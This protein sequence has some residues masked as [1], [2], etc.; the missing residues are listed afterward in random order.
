MNISL[1]RFATLRNYQRIDDR[2][3]RAFYVFAEKN[4]IEELEILK[5]VT[6]GTYQEIIEQISGKSLSNEMQIYELRRFQDGRIYELSQILDNSSRANLDFTVLDKLS[7]SPEHDLLSEHQESTLWD[8]LLQAIFST[9]KKNKQKV[10]AIISLLVANN[11]LK[12][13]DSGIDYSNDASLEK[14]KI[15]LR[16]IN[17]KVVLPLVIYKPLKSRTKTVLLSS[18]QKRAIRDKHNLILTKIEIAALNNAKGE[19]QDISNASISST[20]NNPVFENAVANPVRL[21]SES[22]GFISPYIREHIK[23]RLSVT[24]GVNSPE[25]PTGSS[26]EST[27]ETNING[28]GYSTIEPLSKTNSDQSTQSPLADFP[29]KLTGIPDDSPQI[30]LTRDEII[31]LVPSKRSKEIL[32][33]SNA[34]FGSIKSIEETLSNTIRTKFSKAIRAKSFRSIVAEFNGTK[35]RV[36]TMP[37]NNSFI[38]T[39]ERRSSGY[40]IFFTQYFQ[41]EHTRIVDLRCKFSFTDENIDD[42]NLEGTEITSNFHGFV[43]FQLNNEPVTLNFEKY[44]LVEVALIYRTTS[45]LIEDVFEEFP[46]VRLFHPLYGKLKIKPDFILLPERSPVY[47]VTNLGIIDFMRVEQ[48][49]VCYELGDVSHIENIMAKEYKEKTSKK[50]LM[51]EVSRESDTTSELETINETATTE[52]FELQSEISEALAMEE[53]ENLSLNSGVTSKFFDTT[54][55]VDFG[56]E[57]SSSNS[58]EE[59][60]R[61]ATNQAKE[62]VEKAKERIFSKI[63]RKISS[64]IRNEYE[65]VNKHGF[66][67][68]DNSKPVVSI[69]RWLDKISENQ[70]VNYGKRLVYEFMVPE[71]GMN[72]LMSLQ[73][74]DSENGSNQGDTTKNGGNIL[75]E[76]PVHPKVLLGEDYESVTPEQIFAIAAD[77]GVSLK[78]L[79]DEHISVSKAYSMVIREGGKEYTTDDSNAFNDFQIPEGYLCTDF[80][81]NAIAGVHEGDENDAWAFIIIG[82]QRIELSYCQRHDDSAYLRRRATRRIPLEAPLQGTVAVS[83]ITNDIGTMGFTVTAFCKIKQELLK[84]WKNDS[85]QSLVAEYNNKVSVYNEEQ[86]TIEAS[87]IEPTAEP[88]E[89]EFNYN[90][91]I[92]RKIERNELKRLCIEMLTKGFD[93]ETAWDFYDTSG[94]V[95]ELSLD[96]DFDTRV[97][98]VNF[99]ETAFE[100][101]LMAYKCYPYFYATHQRWHIL[102]HQGGTTDEL[103]KSFLSSGMAKV[104]LPVRT[105]Y[106]NAV[107]FFLSTGEVWH[108]SNFIL[109]TDDDVDI[110]INEELE[111]IREEIRIEDKWQIRVP[112]SLTIVQDGAQAVDEDGLPCRVDKRVETTSKLLFGEEE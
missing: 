61:I 104:R 29:G 91:N 12:H 99:L 82:N 93:I 92:N 56:L 76:P 102:M 67:N 73:T 47:G 51:S 69:F 79:P 4:V 96:A 81:C 27:V 105:G 108:G 74:R 42:I 53:S 14:R 72:F 49:L 90:P 15:L 55:S 10:D 97:R 80:M 16:L 28:Q 58:R 21:I 8:N 60:N 59:S 89:R 88:Q 100:W 45:N 87:L 23:T 19:L 33:N 63:T 34:D 77:Y 109:E 38:L 103:F 6:M 41:N 98:R 107:Q 64:R 11:F 66:D 35:I 68:R 78:K 48:E 85:Y 111:L 46:N 75:M 101:D 25:S 2:S 52:R 83:Y 36:R 94:P 9:S 62:V 3:K 5:G 22:S 26:S 13:Y 17:A 30:S 95:P 71:P 110:S 44:Q 70:L 37:V 50:L 106:E 1:Y 39:L 54:L 112:T 32:R 20:S 86:A 84:T 31:N 57:M 65:E 24:N 40:D 18:S 43:T 7:I